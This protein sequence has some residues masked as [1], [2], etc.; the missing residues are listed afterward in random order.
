MAK[1]ASF[2]LKIIVFV[3]SEWENFRFYQFSEILKNKFNRHKH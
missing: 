1:A 2:S 3:L